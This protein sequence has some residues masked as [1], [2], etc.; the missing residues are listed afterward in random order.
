MRLS[1]EDFKKLQDAMVKAYPSKE[2]LEQMVRIYLERNLDAITRGKTTT[3]IIYS[4]INDWAEPQGKLQDLLNA[5]LKDRPNLQK[6]LIELFD[7]DNQIPKTLF[8]S[9]Q[10]NYSYTSPFDLKS[11]NIW[12]FTGRTSELQNLERLLIKNTGQRRCNIVGISGIGGVGKTALACYFA[13]KNYEEHFPDGV[14]CLRVDDKSLIEIALE[15]ASYYNRKIDNRDKNRGASYV[16]QTIFKNKKALLIFDNAEDSDIKTLFPNFQDK[17]SIIVTT[18]DQILI[19]SFG[20]PFKGRFDL[21]SF[22]PQDSWDFLET[23]LGEER[24]KNEETAVKSIIE[25][26]G[27]L[28]L[29]LNIMG[30]I[31]TIEDSITEYEALLRQEKQRLLDERIND[32]EINVR[33][34]LELSLNLLKKRN[35]ENTINFFACLSVCH[36]NG[37]SFY[38]AKVV[39]G[40][41]K[42]TTHDYLRDLR[43]YSLL[44]GC[45]NLQTRYSF[46]PLIHL[47]A[48]DLLA[49]TPQ[50]KEQAEKRYANFYRNFV[51][52]KNIKDQKVTQIMKQ[53]LNNIILVAEWLQK[54]QIADYDFALR[55]IPFFNKNG[56]WKEAIDII[57]IFL[58]LAY[59]YASIEN[60]IKLS[61]QKAKYL[62]K[63]GNL[64]EAQTVSDSLINIFDKIN[65]DNPT[66]YGHKAS[67]FVQRG[68]IFQKQG[69]LDE[70]IEYINQSFK[71]HQEI[72]DKRG[73]AMSLNT[74]AG[75][76]KQKRNF[77]K[78][79]EI[80][81]QSLK[82]KEEIGDQE[83]IIITLN[84]ISQIYNKIEQYDSAIKI[85]EKCIAFERRNN[86]LTSLSIQLYELA[87][88]Y[89][90]LKQ[91]NNAIKIL[92]ECVSLGKELKDEVGLAKTYHELAI[93]YSEQNDFENA[94][95]YFELNIKLAKQQTFSIPY[96]A[97]ARIFL[98]QGKLDEAAI[99]FKE[100]F[101]Y[102]EKLEYI[103]DLEK[104][105]PQLIR[106][107]IE[108]GE[109]QEALNY[110]ERALNIDS[111]NKIF[112]QQK[113]LLKS[114][115]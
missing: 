62:L 26:V 77:N 57:S 115:K 80:Y 61:I 66:L 69:H 1:G 83:G 34:S 114:K 50:L 60:I 88:I 42:E 97:I 14:I 54:E 46:H 84:S 111:K 12:T 18:R 94:L 11:Q 40:L 90:K 82:I 64:V 95:Y 15:F 98:Q 67:W 89:N 101:E 104:T 27:N 49:K 56:N 112:L 100:S 8:E 37:F 3:E 53:E 106:T 113:Q 22:P 76:Y 44:E 43:Q 110:C 51:K 45:Q 87:R 24:L 32:K 41:N 6:T 105:L 5:V 29:A 16:M 91:Y 74:L 55:L 102:A 71:I 28:P 19:S 99:K 23:L 38:I 103:S 25:L 9:E 31:L 7:E 109:N 79:L 48:Q 47:F 68:R 92:E 35:K 78:S 86:N 39:S 75:V 4:L 107:L 21:R 108:L 59:Q 81:Q 2:D 73:M 85:L 65:K 93:N 72:N 17:Y 13:Q 10:E 96:N 70:A 20:I 36:K 33:A 63:F 52:Y 58:S 30:N